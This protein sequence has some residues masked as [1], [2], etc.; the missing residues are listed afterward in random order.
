MADCATPGRGFPVWWRKFARSP[1]TKISG[2]PGAVRSGSTLTRRLCRSLRRLLGHDATERRAQYACGPQNCAR[3]NGFCLIALADGDRFFA[4]ICDHGAGAYCDAESLDHRA[5]ARRKLLRIH[6]KHAVG[7]FHQNDAGVGGI[8]LAEVPAQRVV[9]IS[10]SAPASSA[11]VGP[12]PTITNVIHARSFS[13]S[14]SRSAVSKA[15]RIL[16]RMSVASSM[17]FRP[18]ANSSHSS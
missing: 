18:G 5:G 11:P 3:R 13:G 9:G 14:G 1:I 10:P 17:V 2:C 16:R 8:N 12:P 7:A 15:N 4:H 6:R